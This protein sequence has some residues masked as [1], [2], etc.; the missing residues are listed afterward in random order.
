MDSGVTLVTGASRGIGL[1][2][3]RHLLAQGQAVVGMA[4]S[5]PEG[6]EFPIVTADLADARATAA[7]LARVVT[8][9]RV[10]RLVNN[11]GIFL[12]AALDEA[13]PQQLDAMMAV[14]LRAPMQAI[15]AVV[16]G[17]R[18][19]GFGRI[20]TIGSR[21]ALGK[22]GR[23]LYSASKAALVGLTRTAAL[24]LAAD[25]IT[26]NCIA[27][28]LVETELFAAN[29]P[30]GTEARRRFTAAIPTGRMGQPEEIAHA[31]AGF[32]DTRAGFT[33]GQVLNI[34]GGLTIGTAAL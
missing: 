10:L 24:E 11:A 7:G 8:E 9:N 3:A 30:P 25:G 5:V 14:N 29:N 28:G 13:T 27:P 15:Q 12:P 33:T 32:L 17:M 6:A 4:R 34:C 26:V 1:A 31:V 16:P 22:P 2:I 18:A 23:M 19:A 20:V 21:A